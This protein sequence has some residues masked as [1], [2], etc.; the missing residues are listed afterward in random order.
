MD[1]LIFARNQ[2][3]FQR[4]RL[5]AELVAVRNGRFF[6]A[7]KMLQMAC[8]SLVCAIAMT[9]GFWTVFVCRNLA[10]LEL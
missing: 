2:Q 1:M 8:R 5:V 6:A 7:L 9:S 3:P 10:G 4:S